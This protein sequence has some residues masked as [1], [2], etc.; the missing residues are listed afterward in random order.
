MT[1]SA[2]YPRSTEKTSFSL[3]M[4]FYYSYYSLILFSSHIKK[5]KIM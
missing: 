5:S 4:P 2:G 3:Y 1:V